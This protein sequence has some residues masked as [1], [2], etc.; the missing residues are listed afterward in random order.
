MT[1]LCITVAHER[2]D[3][4]LAQIENYNACF[5]GEAFHMVHVS[6]G[7]AASFESSQRSLGIDLEAPG[8]VHVFSRVETRWGM[9][10]HAML[11]GV[12]EAARIGLRPDYYYFHT[13][14]DLLVRTGI[15][16]HIRSFDLGAAAPHALSD[17]D[18]WI[19]QVNANPRL[20]VLLRSL[21]RDRP[22]KVRAEG[23]FFRRELFHEMVLPVAMTYGCTSLAEVPE[24]P[25]EEIDLAC[26]VEFY[27]GRHQVARTGNLVATSTAEGQVATTDEIDRLRSGSAHF[28]IKRFRPELSDATRAYVDRCLAGDLQRDGH[29]A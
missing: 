12:V 10:F 23:C 2:P 4:V 1:I 28:G 29:V 13:G 22:L 27:C 21:G 8:N 18:Y 3:L 9:I 11:Q 25:V 6:A 14:A 5:G 24:Y 7:F 16:G 17:Q 15:A 20:P 19:A 26:A